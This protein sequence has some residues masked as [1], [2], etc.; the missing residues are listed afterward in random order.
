M[1]VTTETLSQVTNLLAIVSA[2]PIGTT[3]IR[4]VEVLAAPAAGADGRD[5]HLHRRRLQ[6]R[7]H[8]RPAGRP[9][10]RRL[11][12]PPTSTSSSSGMGL[13]ARMLHSRLA[14]PSLPA[15]ER[16]F[17]AELA[18]A[19]TELAETAEDTLYVDGAAPAAVRVPLPGRLAA[20]RADGDAR[21]P[22]VAARR[23]L[24]GAGRSAT[25]TC[26]SAREN[27]EPALQSLSL[28]A[29]NYGLPQRNLGTVSVIGPT[30]MD[31]ARAIRSVRE[32][33]ARSCRASS[34][35]STSESDAARL[36]RGPRR[37][38]RGRRG[39]DQEGVPPARARAAP[40]R[41]RARPGG[42]G[43]VQG[44]RRGLRGALG[45]RAPPAL[46]RLRPRGP[47]LAAATRRTSRAS[48]RSPTSSRRSSARGG[49]DVGV[50]RRRGRRGGAVQG[51]D[52]ARRGRDRRSPRPRTAS[53]VEV[54][55]D[56]TRA[57][58]R[59]ATATAPSP[60]TPIV[61]C[62]RCHGAGPAPARRSAPRFGQLVRTALCDNCGGDGRDRRAALPHLRRA[63]AWSP[64]SARVDGRRPG[65]HRRR[66]ADPHHR[67]RPRRRARRPAR[68][69][70]RR[71]ARARG[72]ALP[73]RR[74]G[75][76]HGRS[77]SPA[78][79]AALG[80]TIQVPTLDGDV[81]LEVPAGTQ[82]GETIVAAR[83]RH[84][85]AAAAGARATCAW[86]STSRSRAG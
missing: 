4:H 55:Y 31:Y 53:T 34:K 17:L 15:T 32:A 57:R 62:P 76:R 81:P 30:R 61:T 13:G 14:D 72:R 44:G 11:G 80:T 69:P 42:R 71:R 40:G 22:R 75:P 21:A 66:P 56:A 82:P 2:P 74:R 24:R 77:T 41:Q 86:S 10:A 35:T 78:P 73:A 58:A 84:A 12:R 63:R 49:F 36:L 83:P 3:T 6:A 27:R 54:A 8:V 85:A 39:R 43:E 38:P 47:A 65:R 48:A 64:S 59:P 20:Q 60:G 16:A 28:V 23:A 19:F 79:L 67:P 25:S 26:A 46:R 9:R 52:V 70:L 50:R 68:R 51:G 1:R 5:H 37:R 33:A 45:R 29:A 7:V 18:P